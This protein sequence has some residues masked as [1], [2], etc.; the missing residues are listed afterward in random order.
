MYSR[1]LVPLDGSQLAEQ[2]LPYA[3]LF[4]QTFHSEIELLRVMDPEVSN[5]TAPGN[6]NSTERPPYLDRTEVAR[7]LS[8]TAAPMREL[9]LSVS[10][11]VLEGDA[12]SRIVDQAAK[13]PGTL[14]SMSTHGRSGV[15]RW[16]IGSVT[17]KVLQAAVNPVLMVRS[18]DASLPSVVTINSIIT[19]L[20]DSPVAEQALPH[21]VALAK[22]LNAKVVLLTV[23]PSIADY[24]WG[25]DFP[26]AAFGDLAQKVET[27]SA[28][29]LRTVSKKLRAAGI[30]SVEEKVIT[31]HVAA[32]IV[33]LARQTP[34]SLVAMTTHGRSG[35][36]KLVLGGVTDRVVRQSGVP[37]LVVRAQ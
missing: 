7:Y 23:I 31:G 37:V 36:D 13:D 16:L 20:D 33:D 21:T 34:D 15:G 6:K 29:H 28:A 35:V 19:P 10:L 4:S 26:A 32:A 11:I 18:L 8:N 9:G 22:G 2:V 12:A 27:Q 5:R 14:I 30:S 25:V 24:Y 1:I 17:E 3:R